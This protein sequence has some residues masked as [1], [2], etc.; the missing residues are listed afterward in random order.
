MLHNF[1]FQFRCIKLFKKNKQ[2]ISN[3]LFKTARKIFRFTVIRC[4]GKYDF[5]FKNMFIFVSIYSVNYENKT[6]KKLKFIFHVQTCDIAR[7][8]FEFVLF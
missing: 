7:F 4:L 8:F 6:K 3:K 5:Y 1:F 2:T